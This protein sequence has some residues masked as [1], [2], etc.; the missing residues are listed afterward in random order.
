MRV[1]DLEWLGTFLFCNI[2]RHYEE[3]SDVVISFLSRHPRLTFR[4]D[5]GDR[6]LILCCY[7]SFSLEDYLRHSLMF[8]SGNDVFI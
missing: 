3:R 8:V 4:L 5:N 7:V 6:P 2:F 1:P